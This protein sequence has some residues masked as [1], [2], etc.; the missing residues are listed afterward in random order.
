MRKKMS[1]LA[2]LSVLSVSLL[3][4]MSAGC[5]Q[6]ALDL[7]TEYGKVRGKSIN[8]VG[9]LAEMF[10][11]AG[12]EVTAADRWSPRMERYDVVV[13]APDD[14]SPPSSTERN[15]IENWLCAGYHR[16]LIYIGRDYDAETDYWQ[17][18]QATAPPSQQPEIQR[19]LVQSRA[20]NTQRRR[21]LPGKE[22]VDWFIYRSEP[23]DDTAE[24][25]P[26]TLES[27]FLRE[28]DPTK[29]SF[30]PGA[31]FDVPNS[32]AADSDDTD[33]SDA[34]GSDEP[35]AEKIDAENVEVE[36]YEYESFGADDIAEKFDDLEDGYLDQDATNVLL[37]DR[38]DK[39]TIVT[40]VRRPDWHGGQLLL[41]ENGSLL[42]NMPLVE[43][44]N[45]K[46]AAAL[47]DECQDGQAVIFLESGP[48]GLDIA[49]EDPGLPTGLEAFTVWPL[50]VV[51]LHT[52]GLGILFCFAWFPIFGRPREPSR[53]TRSDFK[54]HI[55]ALG[56][57]LSRAKARSY[58]QARI[59]HYQQHVRR[60]S[61]ASHQKKET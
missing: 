48:G 47:I 8:G 58:A 28:L 61:G 34:A 6:S 25:D 14:Y 41:V 16:T 24:R 51:L 15:A 29:L 22:D 52:I 23:L 30:Q 39:R 26:A 27:H 59:D 9:V 46:L 56:E 12:H 42:L 4:S 38:A 44:E 21:G 50:N 45:R 40:Q 10:E 55:D 18:I 54:K 49:P 11:E 5:S 33:A 3:L 13:W 1:V 2:R 57:L 35:R 31:R 17:R 20:L 43:H 32:N 37:Y 7:E 19:R 60:D 53:K 36:S